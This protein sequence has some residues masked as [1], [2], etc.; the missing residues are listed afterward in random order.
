MTPT[1]LTMPETALPRDSV[2]QGADTVKSSVNFALAV[3][4]EKLILTGA[5]A[6]NGT[7]NTSANTLTGNGANNTL[8]GGAG[9]DGTDG[10]GWGGCLQ[11]R[12]R[13]RG[14]GQSSRTSPPGPTRSES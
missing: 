10:R 12:H 8:S 5:V 4:V 3:N 9:N 2:S 13:G 14:R 11:V 7:G 1:W 6:I